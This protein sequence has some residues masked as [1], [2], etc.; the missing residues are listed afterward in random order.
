LFGTISARSLT[1]VHARC[2]LMVALG[3]GGGV[4]AARAC[5]DA[6]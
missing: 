3:E 4:E 1:P 2:A 5:F 6:L